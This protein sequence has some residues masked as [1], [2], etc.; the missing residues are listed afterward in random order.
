[1]AE[2]PEKDD[3]AEGADGADAEAGKAKPDI[4]KLA[5]FIGLPAVILILAGVAGALLLLGGEPD[6]EAAEMAE[7]A[8]AEPQAYLD[9]ISTASPLDTPITVSLVGT[10]RRTTIIVSFRVAFQDSRVAER[11]A[12][13]MRREA[14]RDSYLEFLRTLRPEDLDGSMGHFRF[15][16]ELVRRTNLIIAPLEVDDVLFDEFMMQ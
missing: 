10:G 3:E 12:D 4:K 1:M 6:E 13:P 2:E 11:L 15:K 8:E 7:A 5:L 16:A 9:R 14:L